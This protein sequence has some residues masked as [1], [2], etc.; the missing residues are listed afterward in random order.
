MHEVSPC[1]REE[2]RCPVVSVMVEA[3]GKQGNDADGSKLVHARVNRED[4]VP[5]GILLDCHSGSHMQ[6]ALILG[7]LPDKAKLL[8]PRTDTLVL[9][10]AF[11]KAEVGEAGNELGQEGQAAPKTEP[12]FTIFMHL[13]TGIGVRGPVVSHSPGQLREQ[14]DE[15]DIDRRK[16]AKHEV[17]YGVLTFSAEPESVDQEG[18]GGRHEE[19]RDACHALEEKRLYGDRNEFYNHWK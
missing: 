16:V 10:E 5:L 17:A 14:S 3:D 18:E 2:P 9:L 7:P 11:A 4:G 19:G 15:N 13:S 12:P 1:S 8:E 6:E